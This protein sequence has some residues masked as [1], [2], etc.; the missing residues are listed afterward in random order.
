M[1]IIGILFLCLIVIAIV[2]LMFG[3]IQK[4]S[5]L[6]KKEFKLSEVLDDF[7]EHKYIDKKYDF[8]NYVSHDAYGVSE[9]E[10]CDTIKKVVIEYVPASDRDRYD[11][12]DTFYMIEYRDYCILV[13]VHTDDIRLINSTLKKQE[14]QNKQNYC[15]TILKERLK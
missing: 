3:S 8:S 13:F 10:F 9:C 12:S 1:M 15:N 14:E 6:E 4:R 2:T 11:D 5:S 7:I